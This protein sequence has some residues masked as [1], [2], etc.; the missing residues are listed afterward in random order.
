[1]A[2]KSL[3][4]LCCNQDK[5]FPLIYHL[6][7]NLFRHYFPAE[8]LFR[9]VLS[10]IAAENRKKNA[11]KLLTWFRYGGGCS[12]DGWKS[13]INGKTFYDLTLYF[14][15]YEAPAKNAQG[16]DAK[17]HLH[18]RVLFLAEHTQ[19]GSSAAEIKLTLET[20]LL[21]RY[22]VSLSDLLCANITL[23]TD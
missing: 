16:P 23:T 5:G 13:D 22:S 1:V 15:T 17:A 20:T 6:T 7:L 9:G 12:T 3:P 14:V 2:Q 18:H 21:S 19:P 11:T 4:S 8:V 10:L